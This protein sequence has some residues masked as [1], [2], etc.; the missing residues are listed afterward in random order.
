MPASDP[1]TAAAK[2]PAPGQPF[3]LQQVIDWTEGRLLRGEAGLPLHRLAGIH[4]ACPGD[5][6]FLASE[7]YGAGFA[8]CQASAALVH[9]DFDATK[10]PED[11]ALVTVNRPGAA[12]SHLIDLL[13]RPH[14]PK[15]GEH[16]GVHA[17]ASIGEEVDF[18]PSDVTI[19]PHAVIESGAV[20]GRGCRIGPGAFVGRDA[21]LGRDCVL[22]ANATVYHGC[23]LGDRVVLHAGCVI[24][25]DGFG[26]ELR[27]GRH[28]KIDQ[29]GI[30]QLDDD[31][32][33][34]SCT[35][36]DRARFGR[37]WIGEGTKIDN[38]VQIGHNCVIGK[39]CI[40][41]AQ[42]GMAGSTR[43]GDYCVIAAQTGIAGH[44]EITSQVTLGG[45]SGVSKSVLKPG[46]Y[47][48][49]P[50]LPLKESMKMT[51]LQRRLPEFQR[52]LQRI[53]RRLHDS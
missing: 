53:E 34:G 14:A 5:L 21:R 30:V 41:V 20:I 36:I 3:T 38:L 50:L 16:T 10:A 8:R 9:H 7:K 42:A 40:I 46:V 28:V 29:L 51:V 47:T 32:E 15:P 1:P 22:H 19:G 25:A 12:F 37:T 49:Y 48:G 18:F 26:Y 43:I 31:V 24:G 39:H 17:S 4:D 27:D 45:R 13:I 11:M 6:T 44:L 35:T 52:S 33:V 2:I 23:V